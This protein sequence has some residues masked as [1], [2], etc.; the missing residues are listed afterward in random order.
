M[1]SRRQ[2]NKLE[3]QNLGHKSE[4]A[5]IEP[6]TGPQA[7][8]S[9]CLQANILNDA[10]NL[11]KTSKTRS[12]DQHSQR[13]LGHKVRKWSKKVEK[14][15]RTASKISSLTQDAENKAAKKNR[16]ENCDKVENVMGDTDVYE[17]TKKH[18]PRN[19]ETG[20]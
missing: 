6:P 8:T 17:F 5:N 9:A 15:P 20:T 3:L 12:R 18:S 13:R 10:P 16:H 11:A 4:I 1:T 14:N 2:N 7:Q 19:R